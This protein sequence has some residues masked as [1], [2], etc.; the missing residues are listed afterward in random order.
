MGNEYNLDTSVSAPEEANMPPR[1]KEVIVKPLSPL[2][3][4]LSLFLL[5]FLMMREGRKEDNH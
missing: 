2:L 1:L 5:L 3:V 4:S